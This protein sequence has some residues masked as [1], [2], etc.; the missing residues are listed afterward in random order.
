MATAI[1]VVLLA[2]LLTAC[3]GS[4]PNI[5]TSNMD[6]YWRDYGKTHGADSTAG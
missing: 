5:P 6:N 4:G 3:A 2:T 1:A